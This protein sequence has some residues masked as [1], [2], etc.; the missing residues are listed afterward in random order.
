MSGTGFEITQK[1][2]GKSGCS[3]D[4][5]A[6]GGASHPSQRTQDLELAVILAAWEHLTDAQRKRILAVVRNAAQDR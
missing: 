6:W 3:A 5:G 4:R 2:L 1:S